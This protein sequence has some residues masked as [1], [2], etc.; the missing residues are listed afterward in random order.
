MSEVNR[1]DSQGLTGAY[2]RREQL[3]EAFGAA[4]R[5][6][7]RPVID[8]YLPDGVTDP[9]LL[10]DLL[11]ADLEYRLKAGESICVED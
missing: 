6:S 7:D 4:W 8:D 1:A 9:E 10:L 2:A 11:Q 5:R 3:L